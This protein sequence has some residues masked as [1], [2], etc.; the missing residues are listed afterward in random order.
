MRRIIAIAPGLLDT[1]GGTTFTRHE[2]AFVRLAELANVSRIAPMPA[3]GVQEAAWLGLPPNSIRLALGPLTVAALG[4]E[5]P[6]K[7]VHYAL[8]LMS[9]Q[10]G[11]IAK[12][13]FE[14]PEAIANR[15]LGLV[16]QLHT[17]RLTTLLGERAEHAMVLEDGSLDVG[18]RSPDEASGKRIEESLP[19]GDDERVLR[20]FIDDSVNLLA[21]QEFNL[22]RV[23]EGLPPLNLLWP[24]APGFREAVPNL[25]LQRGEPAMVHSGSLRLEGLTRLCKWSHGDR[26]S[27][28][29]GT[30][31]RFDEVVVSSRMSG[32]TIVLFDAFAAFRQ[33]EK[34][35]ELEWSTREF[36]RRFLEPLLDLMI[37]EPLRVTLV[38]PSVSSNGIGLAATA[39]KGAGPAAA[40]FDERPLDDPH[41]SARDA[42]SIVSAAMSTRPGESGSVN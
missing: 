27:F 40:P 11:L 8:T 19:E 12:P 41:I 7:S 33:A 4:Y 20:Q 38:A 15:V 24:H 30:A 14:V 3:E 10:D 9:L 35:E 22:R 36:G 26:R 17:R 2:A 29:Q 6:A 34:W 39:E 32:L 23:D 21:E 28:G 25:L 42:W 31:V 16:K 18:V 5:P 37:D 1:D 13:T